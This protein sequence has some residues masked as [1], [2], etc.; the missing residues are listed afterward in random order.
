MMKDKRQLT[1]PCGFLAPAADGAACCPHNL[2]VYNLCRMKEKGLDRWIEASV[3]TRKNDFSK[4]FV[5]GKGQA[6]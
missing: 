5:V 2:K 6:E 4:K 3:K 1:A